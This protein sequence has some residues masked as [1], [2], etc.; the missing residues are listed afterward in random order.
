MVGLLIAVDTDDTANVRGL[1][2]PHSYLPLQ[3]PDVR[4]IVRIRPTLARFATAFAAQFRV[5]V[6]CNDVGEEYEPVLRS[7]KVRER[8]VALPSSVITYTRT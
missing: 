3:R 2:K 7:H 8:D 6:P 1:V 5:V 4:V